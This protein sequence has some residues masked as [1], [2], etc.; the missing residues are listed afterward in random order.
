MKSFNEY[1]NEY[2]KQIE[3]GDIKEA[4]KGLMNYI[5]DLRTHFKKIKRC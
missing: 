2:R 4:Y 3:K 5:M 1:V